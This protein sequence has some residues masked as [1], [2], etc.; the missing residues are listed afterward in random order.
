MAAQVRARILITLANAPTRGGHPRTMMPMKL[1]IR[2]CALTSIGLASGCQPPLDELDPDGAGGEDVGDEAEGTTDANHEECFEGSDVLGAPGSAY[3]PDCPV[4]CAGPY[5]QELLDI[6]WTRELELEFAP[7]DL[8]TTNHVAWLDETRAL[9]VAGARMATLARESGELLALVDVAPEIERVDDLAVGAGGRIYAAWRADDESFVGEL[10]DAGMLI[11]SAELGFAGEPGVQ[12][13]SGP[14]GVTALRPHE[15]LHRFDADGEPLGASNVD[16]ISFA[17]TSEGYVGF[18][19]SDLARLHWYDELGNLIATQP[20]AS[21]TDETYPL[22]VELAA[23]GD[24]EVALGGWG[25]P[26]D[27]LGLGFVRVFLREFEPPLWSLD[28]LRASAWCPD[29]PASDPERPPTRVREIVALEGKRIVVGGYEAIGWPF[30]LVDGVEHPTQPFVAL[31]D[32]AAGGE[33]LGHDR[34]LWV[35]EVHDLDATEG[36]AIALMSRATP[37]S[38]TLVVR[39]YSLPD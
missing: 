35:G 4:V 36:H 2:V 23:I 19:F 31:Y 21:E 16:V 10:S 3:E 14:E 8:E 30:D 17:R 39:S 34:G 25:L 7:A 18:E 22:S 33:L 6:E 11:W 37:T 12:V 29:E 24:D 1:W 26:P 9:V 15:Q 20:A 32:V 13:R 38:T 28:Y 5:D 27:L